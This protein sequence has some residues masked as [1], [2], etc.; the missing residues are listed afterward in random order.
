MLDANRICVEKKITEKCDSTELYHIT[1]NNIIKIILNQRNS[2]HNSVFDPFV[3]RY[4]YSTSCTD[5]TTEAVSQ[6]L[7]FWYFFLFLYLIVVKE[8]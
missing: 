2:T 8:L 7:L 1:E 5:I 4:V 6:H 3:F